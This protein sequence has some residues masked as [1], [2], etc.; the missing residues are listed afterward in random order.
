MPTA[1]KKRKNTRSWYFH[2]LVVFDFPYYSFNLFSFLC[3]ELGIA[4]AQGLCQGPFGSQRS[5]KAG[6]MTSLYEVCTDFFFAILAP[7]EFS[8]FFPDLLVK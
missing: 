7:E 2:F 4:L 6:L 1:T 5:E 8:L 3:L